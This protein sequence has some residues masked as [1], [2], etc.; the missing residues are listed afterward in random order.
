MGKLHVILIITI[1]VLGGFAL[2]L[3]IPGDSEESGINL[4][5]GKAVKDIPKDNKKDNLEEDNI[6]EN[7]DSGD[8]NS[9]FSDGGADS[10]NELPPSL[11]DIE[12][13][14]CGFYFDRYDV[15]GGY[16]TLGECVQEGQSCFCKLV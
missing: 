6:N 14:S 7:T 5:S 10:N 12:N 8:S 11:P 4:M 15:C 1:L 13:S 3:D 2:F 16:C 9:N